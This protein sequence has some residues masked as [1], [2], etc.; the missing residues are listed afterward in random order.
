VSEPGKTAE[1]LTP[2]IKGYSQIKTKGSSAHPMPSPSQKGFPSHPLR[3]V[4]MR[5]SDISSIFPGM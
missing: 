2:E 3:D 5:P 1:K 4:Q